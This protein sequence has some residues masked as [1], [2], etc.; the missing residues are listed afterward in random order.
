MSILTLLQPQLAAIV[1]PMGAGKSTLIKAVLGLCRRPAGCP[2]LRASR[3]RGSV[4]ASAMC[5][6]R[7][8]VDWDFPV[9]VLDVVL[10]GTYGQLGWIRRP[11]KNEARLVRQCLDK[12][13]LLN[14]ERSKSVSSPAGSS[15]GFPGA[16]LSPRRPTSISWTSRWPASMRA[17][18]RTIFQ[19]LSELR[20]SGKAIIAVHQTTLRTVPQYFDYVVLLK[21]PPRRRRPAGDRLSRREPPQKLRRPSRFLDPPPKPSKRRARAL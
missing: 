9:S 17:T 18:E 5:R 12:V 8:S 6:R 14:Y 11:G 16:S 4:S 1:G 10:M 19:L 15:S 7:E 13:G 21:R 20:E 2:N 3:C